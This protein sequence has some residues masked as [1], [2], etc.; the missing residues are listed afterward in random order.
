MPWCVACWSGCT[1]YE[2]EWKPRWSL[3]LW[4]GRGLANALVNALA[5]AE[6]VLA[7]R[8]RP[9]TVK[10]ALVC[11]S[12]M[13]PGLL[14]ID[15]DAVTLVERDL[16]NLANIVILDCPDPDTT[17]A[18]GIEG[19][20]VGGTN[21]ARL[22][23]ILPHCDVLLVTTTQQKYRSARV[24]EEL[25]AAAPGARLV[26]I[27]THGD[28]DQDIRDDWSNSLGPKYDAGRIFL[29]DSLAALSDAQNGAAP[30]GEFAALVDLLTRQLA[31]IAAKRIRRANFLDLIEEAL[32]AC[33]RRMDEA[34]TA[35]QQLRTA[36]D[37]QRARLGALAARMR[38]AP[39]RPPSV[40][41]S[42]ARTGRLALGI[43]PFR[44]GAAGLPG[45]GRTRLGNPAVASSNPGSIG[46]LGC[47]RRDSTLEKRPQPAA[48]RLGR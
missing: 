45:T 42:T 23:Q 30:R 35:V 10:P 15:P 47:D 3:R 22:R 2:R 46:S 31:G 43:Q 44:A 39:R 27:Q 40:G 12:G 25:A 5:G 41:E 16:P 21:L 48:C 29:I 14:G 20:H 6:V 13:T 32:T 26:F 19:T 17:E 28:C 37:Q 8:S 24:A 11:H 4:G 38:R 36:I 1:G 18:A 34:M 7:G 33:G 9:T